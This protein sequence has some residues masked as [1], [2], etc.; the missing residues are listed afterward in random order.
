MLTICNLVLVMV[1]CISEVQIVCSQEC[2][3][4]SQRCSL[5][6]DIIE[7]SVN[8]GDILHT[9]IESMVN[10]SLNERLPASV[11]EHFQAVQQKINDTIDEK[12]VDSHRDTP[13]KEFRMIHT[14]IFNL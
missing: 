1:L 2:S 9:I 12:I 3:C 11:E 13:G 5:S 7:V 6:H 4:S 10:Q 8:N 14:I